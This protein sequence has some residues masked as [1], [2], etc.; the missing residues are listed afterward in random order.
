MSKYQTCA[1]SAPWQPPIPLDDEEKGYPVGRFCKH[2]CRSMAVIR[3]PEVCESCTQY[4]D[5]AKLITIN[6]GDYHADIY[7]DRLEDMPLSNIRKVFKL[8]LAD[9]WSNEGAIRQMTLYLDAAVIESKGPGNRPARSIRTAGAMCSIRKPPQR[10]PPKAPEN[11]RLTA[12]VKRSK[13]RHERWV[14]LQPAGLRPSLMQTPE[15]NLTVK[16]T[17]DY[18]SE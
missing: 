9:P 3:D 15:C 7:F 2:A 14:K 18:V 5:P 17:K 4:T 11:N 13:A 16:E 10:G 8:L 1:H 12:A 6:T